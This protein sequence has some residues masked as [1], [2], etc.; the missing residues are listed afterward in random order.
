MKQI[1]FK[2]VLP[3][4]AAVV[5]FLLLSVFLT[6]PALEGKAV[7]QNDVIQWKA[8]AQQSFEFNKKYGHFPKWTNAM[9]GGMPAYQIALAPEKPMYIHPQYVQDILTLG[10]PK[11]VFYL[12]ICALCFYL[13]CIVIGVNP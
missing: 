6:K 9:M 7:Q 5:I 13:L 12:F 3:H 8:M 10:F 2:Q 1:N 4:L 11:P